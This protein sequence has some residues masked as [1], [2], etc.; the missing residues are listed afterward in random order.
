L[1]KTIE[2]ER[3]KV[4]GSHEHTHPLAKLCS[5]QALGSPCNRQ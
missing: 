1:W 5:W 4:A 3:K 2:R